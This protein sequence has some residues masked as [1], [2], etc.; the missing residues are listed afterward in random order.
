MQ[1]GSNSGG[2]VE[3][4]CWQ[5]RPIGMAFH[6]DLQPAADLDGSKAAKLQVL[7]CLSLTSHSPFTA[8]P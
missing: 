5:G 8:F 1:V 3:Q 7:H 2:G 6:W 4:V